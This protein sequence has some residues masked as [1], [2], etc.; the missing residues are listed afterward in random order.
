MVSTH[1]YL[2]VLPDPQFENYYPNSL[3]QIA[4]LSP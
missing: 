4:T 1:N 3:L 2:Q